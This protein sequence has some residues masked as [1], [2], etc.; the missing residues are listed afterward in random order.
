MDKK[1][2][3]TVLATCMMLLCLTISVA[4]AATAS[5]SIYSNQSGTVKSSK[6]ALSSGSI[7]GNVS[8]SSTSTSNAKMTGYLY[9]HGSVFEVQRA[10]KSISA[11]G[12]DTFSWNNPNGETGQFDVRIYSPGGHDG[13]CSAT[14]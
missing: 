8:S 3:I 7:S 5:T 6:K 1:K 4:L 12:Y 9:T 11:G 13:S 14:N 2:R 10:S